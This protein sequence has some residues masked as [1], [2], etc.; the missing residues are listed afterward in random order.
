MRTALKRILAG[1]GTPIVKT[2]LSGVTI[3]ALMV[4]SHAAMAA[5]SMSIVQGGGQSV[6]PYSTFPNPLSVMF[7]GTSPSVTLEWKVVA[8]NVSIYDSTFAYQGTDYVQ[9][10]A[11]APGTTATIRLVSGATAGPVSVQAICQLG[12]DTVQT[13]TFNETVQQQPP[14]LKMDEVSGSG[15]SGAPNSTLPNPLVVQLTPSPLYE[16]PSSIN[17]QWSVLSGDATFDATHSK[18]YTQNVALPVGQGGAITG[19]GGPGGGQFG[20]ALA[21]AAASVTAQ[22]S[23]DLGST[24][25]NVN[26]LVT[27]NLC[28]AGSTKGFLISISQSAPGAI[29]IYSGND[30]SGVVGSAS[31]DPLV[32]QSGTT[33]GQTISWAV[34]SG[35]AT[36]AAASSLTDSN[37]RA[38][39]TFSYGS[40]SG[41][42]TIE[43]TNGTSSV[44]FTVT[45]TEAAGIVASG[46]NQSGIVGSPLQPFV[47]QVSPA[48]TTAKGLSQIPVNWA[49]VSGGGTLAS[50]TT[51][52]DAN[53]RASNTLTLGPNV[54]SSMV[55]ATLPGNIVLNFSAKALAPGSVTL[56]KISGD[57][58]SATPGSALQPFIVDVG[59]PGVSVS[60]LVLQG[61]GT[62]TAAST[63]SDSTGK[64]SNILTLGSSPGV[65]IVQAV[66]PG[67]NAV[68]YTAYATTQ[69]SGSVQFTIVS[70]DNQTLV[71]KQPSA[72]LVVK[73]VGAT[74]DP[75]NGAAIQW[76]VS[77]TSGALDNDTTV[78]GADGQSQNRLT[79]LLPGDYTVTAKLSGTTDVPALTFHFGNGVANLPSLSK[80]QISV[81]N[82]IDKACPALASLPFDQ[83]TP[84]QKDLLFR[85][86]EIVVGSGD[87]PGQVPGALNKLL[88][89]KALPQRSLAQGVQ[90]TQF[91]NLNTRMGELRQGIR[92]VSLRGLTVVNDGQSLPLAMLGDMF[93]KDPK[94]DDEIGKDFARWGFF[95]TGMIVRG[96]FDATATR[97][98]FDYHNASLTAGVDYRFNDSFVAGG[99]LG[100]NQNRSTLDQSLGNINVDSYSLN[101]YFTWYHN[102]DFYLEGSVVFDWLNFDLTRNISYQIASTSGGPDTSVAQSALASPNGHQSSIAFSFGKDINRGAW[103][104]SPYLRGVYT[105]LNLQAFSEHARDPNAPGSGLITSVDSRSLT[106][107]LGVIGGRLSYTTSY[108]W[109]VLI[110]N[111]ML[112]W[113]HEFRNDPQT[114]V[115]RFVAD[116]TQTPITITEDAPDSS[117]FNVGIGL[118]AVLPGGRSGY[119]TWEHLVGYAGAHENRFSLGIRI[120]F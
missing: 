114:L 90:T 88:N 27:C 118:N 71:P 25:G 100:Y 11:T 22:V 83:L 29:A 112:E 61:G 3:C 60:W 77:G 42:I 85:C 2:L 28:D 36:L 78:T 24:L 113:N 50:A 10:L 45:S 117:Y 87:H 5:N 68:M 43:A 31:E 18:Q 37:G 89:N 106:S 98:G 110:P 66:V 35:D 72:P 7:S 93:R 39:M 105:H 1:I 15:Q 65:N 34:I 81:A 58:Q 116:P 54:G 16:G 55:T 14:N 8:G 86:S 4:V 23:L 80:T 40:T 62:L 97:P 51:M 21:A 9:Q 20:K 63:L 56:T 95:A 47:V 96:G 82:A 52:T 79:V 73:V 91:N 120:E 53:G 30:Q 46:N 57:T 84:E 32:V 104:I 74:G 13:L 12:C 76:S 111:A 75:V 41:P 119:V 17:L 99:A 67:T 109:G 6:Y 69:V 19:G 115:T 92:G 44:D 59:I 49:V 108:D 70:G 103:A 33:E 64:T 48:P 38:S 102:E 101:G 94:Q 26:V 107:E